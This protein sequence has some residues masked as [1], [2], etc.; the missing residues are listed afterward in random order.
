PG[1]VSK[2][3]KPVSSLRSMDES[4]AEDVP[5]KEPR[6]DDEEEESKEDV[7]G[8]DAGVQGEG[9]ARSNPGAQDEGQSRSNPDEQAEGQAGPDPGNVEAS[10]PMPSPVVHA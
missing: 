6:V 1:S 7:L 4:V 10:Q 5:E 2:R 8:A 9:Q 3:R